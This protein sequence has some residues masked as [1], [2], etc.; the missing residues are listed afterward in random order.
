MNTKESIRDYLIESIERTLG[1]EQY[2]FKF[3]NNY[4]ASII[5][6]FGTYGNEK[7]LWE[8]AVIYGYMD[9]QKYVWE[10]TYDTEITDDV[11][12]YLNKQD[13]LELLIR[14]KNLKELG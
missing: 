2:I 10:L 13:I 8:L 7:G 3:D 12:G 4:G 14:I 5:R 6:G 11:I 1:G 9:G